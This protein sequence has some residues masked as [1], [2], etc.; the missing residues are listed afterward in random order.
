MRRQSERRTVYAIT[1]IALLAIAGGWAFAATFVNHSPPPQNSGVTVVAPNGAA[2][3]VQST[4]LITI[5]GALNSAVVPAGA[6]AGSGDGLNSTYGTNYVIPSCPVLNCSGNFSA[7]D[8]THALTTGD[9]ALQ[10]SLI[11]PQ[12][13]TATGFDVQVEV[14]FTS[15][16]VF[17]SG[18]FDTGRSTATGGTSS[19][20]VFLFVD[21]GMSALNPE[22]VTN[23][24][25]TLNGCSSATTCP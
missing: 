10:V 23:I 9:A 15:G 3:V 11:A 20:S 5:S 22:S 24:V 8:A 25:I 1:V 2:E 21:F 13:A 14:L 6:Q 18:Y 4:Q 12:T 17:G 16:S 19:I 7:V